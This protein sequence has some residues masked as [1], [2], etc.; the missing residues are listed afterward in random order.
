MKPQYQ[1]PKKTMKTIFLILALLLTGLDASMLVAQDLD[2]GK[3]RRERR[4]LERGTSMPNQSSGLGDLNTLEVL[5]PFRNDASYEIRYRRFSQ[6]GRDAVR[7][8]FDFNM[9]VEGDDVYDATADKNGSINRLRFSFGVAPGWERHFKVQ[10]SWQNVE[11]SPY[12][13]LTLPIRVDAYGTQF[14]DTDGTRYIDG[15][16][17]EV[18]NAWVSS[19]GSTIIDNSTRSQVEFGLRL[20]FGADIYIYK[21]AFV[22]FECSFGPSISGRPEVEREI[23]GQDAVQIASAGGRFSLNTAVLGGVRLGVRF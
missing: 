8:G 20:H 13:A 14:E 6:S 7:L 19:T 18:R 10:T 2:S 4:R 23:D 16:K 5:I 11:V 9:D 21:R 22:G 12:F 3:P 15:Y 1:I 17:A